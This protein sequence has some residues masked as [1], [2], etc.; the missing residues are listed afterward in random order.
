MSDSPLASLMCQCKIMVKSTD[1]G[2]ADILCVRISRLR[3]PRKQICMVVHPA[4]VGFNPSSGVTLLIP[5]MTYNREYNLSTIRGMSSQR[6]TIPFFSFCGTTAV[7]HQRKRWNFTQGGGSGQGTAVES[8]KSDRPWTLQSSF[9]LKGISGVYIYIPFVCG[10]ENQHDKKFG[11][12]LKPRG[13][14]LEFTS[15]SLAL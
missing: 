14:G 9:S 11:D 4:Q 8:T 10:I 12:R 15:W 7:R 2:S 13:F 5:L 6:S 3:G 1:F